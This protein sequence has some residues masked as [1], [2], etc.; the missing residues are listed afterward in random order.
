M[1]VYLPGTENPY[2]LTE[3]RAHAF[4]PRHLSA[5]ASFVAARLMSRHASHAEY[6]PHVCRKSCVACFTGLLA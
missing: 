5:T 1:I 2:A 4:T 6:C 3:N